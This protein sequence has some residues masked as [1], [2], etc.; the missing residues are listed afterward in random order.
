LNAVF[1]EKVVN[2]KGFVL[3]LLQRLKKQRLEEWSKKTQ[4][5]EHLVPEMG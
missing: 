1:P 5:L 3:E 2:Q 4:E